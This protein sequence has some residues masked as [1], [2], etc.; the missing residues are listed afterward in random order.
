MGQKSRNVHIKTHKCIRQENK[1]SES[2]EKIQI[3]TN[4]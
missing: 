2:E 3:F 1:N 4:E